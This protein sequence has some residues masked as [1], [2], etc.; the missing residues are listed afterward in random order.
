[1]ARPLVLH[2][3]GLRSRAILFNVFINDLDD[4]T[5]CTLSYCE[6]DIKPGGWVDRPEG[7]AA[8]TSWRNKPT[9][10][11]EMQVLQLWKNKPM[12]RTGWSKPTGK[13]LSRKGPGGS[14]GHQA[15]QEPAM[16]PCG[17]GS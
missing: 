13:Q 11:F 3:K 16:C 14:S 15:D 8:S 10:I 2:L 9:A 4:G 5:E 6:G 12:Y 17:K 7:C 1:M